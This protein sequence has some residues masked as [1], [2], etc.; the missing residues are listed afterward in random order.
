MLKINTEEDQMISN[1]S[2]ILHYQI[3]L[4]QRTD[5]VIALWTY[6]KEM[7]G[8]QPNCVD[9]KTSRKAINSPQKDRSMKLN[10]SLV[11]CKISTQ[12]I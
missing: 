3:D 11:H 12:I 8:K 10:L 5:V 2:L 1:A 7:I 9:H 6:Q 4:N